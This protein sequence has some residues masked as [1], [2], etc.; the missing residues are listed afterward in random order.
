MIVDALLTPPYPQIAR[1]ASFLGSVLSVG[2]AFKPLGRGPARK[3]SDKSKIY[4]LA[5]RWPFGKQFPMRLQ[6]SC[7]GGRAS[8]S[9]QHGRPGRPLG[10]QDTRNRGR[11]WLPHAAFPNYNFTHQD[12]PQQDGQK[13]MQT[14]TTKNN[15][16]NEPWHVS[17]TFQLFKHR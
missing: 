12:S 11:R 3:Q 14:T 15:I 16:A 2:L 9:W 5:E 4:R 17:C 13:Q 8:V 7:W 1:H 10:Q 6:V